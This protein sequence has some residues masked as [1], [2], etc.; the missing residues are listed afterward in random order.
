MP[1][2]LE[3]KKGLVLNV[4]NDRSIAWH[5]A[6]NAIKHGAT[7]GFGFLPLEKMERRVRK[8]LEEMGLSNPWL[9]PCDVSKDQDIDSFMS[10]AA[11]QFGTIDF[12]VHSLAFANKDY[13]AIGKFTDTPRQVYSQAMD[14]SA[15]SLLGLTRAALPL[16][17][18]GG[19]IIALTYLGSEK[20]VPG[21]NVMGVAKAALEATARYLAFE[22]GQKNIR[23]NTISAGPVRTLSAMAVGGIDDMFD[24]VQRKAPLKRNIEADEVGKTAVYLLS[25]LSSGVTGENIYVDCGF[26][27]VGL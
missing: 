14:I 25:D 4:A 9:H 24:H 10:A 23:V 11:Q 20:V 16:M 5:I 22:L 2:L 17:P 26:N 27:I 6:N 19:S 13:L 8:A 21:Y 3:G 7:C 1:G 18:N 12:L 15:Y